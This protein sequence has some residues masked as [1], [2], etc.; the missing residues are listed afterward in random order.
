M[1]NSMPALHGAEAVSDPSPFRADVEAVQQAAHRHPDGSAAYLAEL[2]T[3][4]RRLQAR[5]PAEGEVYAELLFVADHQ[6]GPE[7]LA[8]ARQILQW[9]APAEIQEKA[10][11]VLAKKASL[12][13]P[14]NLDLVTTQ[15]TRLHLAD[16]RG[17]V[18][19]L[20]FWATWCPP[21][22]E[23]LPE[24]RR[25][26]AQHHARG[27]EIV[28]FSFDDDLGT[29]RRFIASEKVPWAQVADG[30]GWTDSPRAQESGITSLPAMWLVDRQGL[31]RD[32]DARDGL[33]ERIERL[34]A[35]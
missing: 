29:L 32:I 22:R 6:S 10:R 34:L 4:F 20:D 16:L 17:K 33:A 28:G 15:G 2:E 19:L 7:A 12:G 21:C 31:L 11:G 8:L 25:L 9:P 3:G 5:Y 24:L 14:L 1:F 13:Q 23:K 27:L 30:K 35:E 18:V 26:Y